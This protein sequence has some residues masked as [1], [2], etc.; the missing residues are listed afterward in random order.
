MRIHITGASGSGT[1]TLGRALAE[2]RGCPHFDSDDYFWL[3]DPPFERQ[4]P[5]AER[6]ALLLA[7]LQR[8]ESWVLSGSVS[9]WG[10]IAIPLFDLVVF[11]L[12]P[13]ETRIAR[14]RTR[15][16]TR[17]GEAALAPGG[18]MHEKHEAF[19]TWAMAY[20]DGG[21]DMRSRRQHEQWL[22]ALAC[23]TIRLEGERSVEE[24]LRTLLVTLDSK[25]DA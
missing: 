17:F 7:D 6:E 13:G 1:S 21:L 25:R 15:G 23:E 14:L 16:R 3:P 2:P 12:V 20:D 8:H 10:D 24:N 9:G 5:Q 18:E 22:S 4:R 11:L 19:I